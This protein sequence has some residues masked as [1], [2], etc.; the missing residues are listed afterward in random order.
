MAASSTASP[1]GV[2]KID[3]HLEADRDHNAEALDLLALQSSHG[4]LYSSSGLTP[5]SNLSV[6]RSLSASSA[7]SLVEPK[8]NFSPAGRL[9]GFLAGQ[10][11]YDT[12]TRGVSSAEA[13]RRSH[14]VHYH[15]DS[16]IDALGR[17][18]AS[19]ATSSTYRDDIDSV[20]SPTSISD[21]DVARVAN[22]V[23]HL[24]DSR[25]VIGSVATK[26]MA[27]SGDNSSV[28]Q[29][30][31]ATL[32]RVL[33]TKAWFELH[34]AFVSQSQILP[35]NVSQTFLPFPGVDGVYNPLQT[36][37]NRYMRARLKH[38]LEIP[39]LST[40]TPASTAFR[41]NPNS[42]IIW[43]VDVNE[44]FADWGWR[45]RNRMLMVGRNDLPIYKPVRPNRK[46]VKHSTR[47]SRKQNAEIAD[48]S[49][50]EDDIDQSRRHRNG[51]LH[52]PDAYLSRGI[53]ELERHRSRRP[54]KHSG[55]QDAE[56]RGTGKYSKYKLRLRRSRRAKRN[57]SDDEDN[58]D[59][60]D[61]SSESDSEGSS[62]SESETRSPGISGYSSSYEDEV[63][64]HEKGERSKFKVRS[65]KSVPHSPTG[66]TP[67]SRT[68]SPG[69]SRSSSPT[70]SRNSSPRR[71]ARPS[72]HMPAGSQ[73]SL[74]SVP[75]IAATNS[76][77][78]Q[79]G[80]P[81]RN[82]S[83]S[84]SIK[85]ELNGGAHRHH[86]HRH[87]KH[88]SQNSA[89]DDDDNTIDSD[90]I[91]DPN[92]S[93]IAFTSTA[94][95]NHIERDL[96]ESHKPTILHPEPVRQSS[97]TTSTASSN[98]Q[99][100]DLVAELEFLETRFFLHGMRASTMCN[101]YGKFLTELTEPLNDS[102]AHETILQ[103]RKSVI[104]VTHNFNATTL[105]PSRSLLASLSS[106]TDSLTSTLSSNFRSRFDLAISAADQLTAEVSTT[107]SLQARRLGESLECVEKTGA[108]FRRKERVISMLER[109]GYALLERLVTLLL[110]AVWG[111]VSVLRIVRAVVR[112]VFW[113]ARWLIWC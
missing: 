77:E 86:H 105:A 28:V 10:Q 15:G 44:M 75:V 18:D 79:S 8:N 103:L 70:K 73:K 32:R 38:P 5:P 55:S 113:I 82:S 112:G 46:Q 27:L 42:N 92:I 93:R 74:L 4:Q 67:T 17:D 50:G 19:T 89:M 11:P 66:S 21:A 26:K 6:A 30:S 49:N 24:R 61:S 84:S 35:H 100:A 110:W 78:S 22:L 29:P 56:R 106:R 53:S 60:Y 36:I 62:N 34:A 111:V 41:Y 47:E 80:S 2:R 83:A 94:T 52:L 81:S 98:A 31:Q 87:H 13:A 101:T 109:A 39:E 108:L 54:Q 104:E 57:I 12:K 20:G 90:Q 88:L 71:P 97:T 9:S 3:S 107:L 48:G 33:R 91:H 72:P 85:G 58:Y 69:S 14:Y 45:E 25:N 102:S 1:Q 59:S 96:Q 64:N 23:V 40:I 16:F 99:F 7:A 68:H 37:R 76:R 95:K 43:E 63:V 65:H 51:A